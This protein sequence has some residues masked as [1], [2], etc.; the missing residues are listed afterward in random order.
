MRFVGKLVIIQTIFI[1]RQIEFYLDI[2]INLRLLTPHI[3]PCYT[4]KMAVVSWP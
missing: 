3:M 1:N 4:H 2:A